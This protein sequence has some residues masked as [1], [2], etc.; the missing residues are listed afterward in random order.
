LIKSILRKIPVK[1][2]GPQVP[3][4]DKLIGQ[5]KNDLLRDMLPI[6]EDEMKWLQEIAVTK[7]AKLPTR[8]DL[9]KF[10]SFLDNNLVLTYHNGERWYDLHPLLKEMLT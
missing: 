6:P 8:T 7:G 3:V 1:A 9:P 4:A 2:E 10:V 5:A